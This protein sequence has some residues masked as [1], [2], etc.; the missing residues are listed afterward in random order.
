MHLGRYPSYKAPSPVAPSKAWFTDDSTMGGKLQTLRTCWSIL[1]EEGPVLGCFI[2]AKKS[3]LLTKPDH[4]DLAAELF[5]DTNVD[6][7]VDRCRHLGAVL[8]IPQ[9]CE[10]FLRSKVQEWCAVA[11][12]FAQH[13]VTQPQAAVGYLDRT[14]GTNRLSLLELCPTPCLL[15]LRT[16]S[17]LT[18]FQPSPTDRLQVILKGPSSIYPAETDDSVSSSRPPCQPSTRTRKLSRQHS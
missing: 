12:V 7:R 13:A 2:N 16:G 17:A 15:P 18:S 6:I 11:T 8:G 3:I 10:N 5:G 1:Q 14:C 9:Y 4:A